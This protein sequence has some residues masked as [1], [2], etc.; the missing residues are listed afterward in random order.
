MLNDKGMHQSIG[1]YNPEFEHDACGVGFVANIKGEKSHEIVQNGIE[2]LENLKHRGAVGCDPKTG[3]GAGITTQIPHE[4]FVKECARLDYDLPDRGNYG[5]GLVFLPTIAEDRH[6]VE[7]VIEST[8]IDEDQV[9]LGLRDVPVN[10]DEIGSVAKSVMP[11]FK[12]I[13]VERGEDIDPED[14]ER[15]L[16]VI[17][18][19]IGL[20]IR[21]M[22]FGQKNYFYICNLSS[23]S[24]IYK[25]QLMAEQLR[26]FFPDLS[27]I[28]Y[29]SSIALVHSRYSTNT[30]PTWALAHPFRMIAHNGEINTLK[31][32]KNWFNAREGLFKGS[33]FE[34]DLIK[35]APIIAPSKSDSAAF[36]NVLEA[37]VHSGRSLPHALMMM[38]PE[39]FSAG[40]QMSEEKEAFYEY[41]SCLMEP[42]DGPSAI[43]FTDGRYIGSILDRNGLRPLRYWITDSDKIVM[44]SETGTLD[45]EEK[46][47]LK[48]GRIQPGKIFLV[49]TE[50]G[51]I[52]RDEEI[53]NEIVNKQDY[54]KWIDENL[55]ILKDQ[56]LEHTTP[57]D[58]P[59]D[60]LTKQKIFG[61]TLEDIKYIIKPMAQD[62]K[63]ATGSMGADTPLAI[64][65]KKPQLLFNYFKQQFAQVTNP[66][67]DPIREE[68]VMSQQVIL[69]PEQN[70]LSESPLHCKRLKLRRPV[71]TNQGL[72]RIRSLDNNNLISETISLVYPINKI[73]GLERALSEVF[74]R[75]DKLVEQGVSLIILSDKGVDKDNLPIPSLLACSGLHH[76]LVKKGTRTKVSIILETGEAREVHHF[77]T[78]IGFGANAINPYLAFEIIRDHWNKDEF[79]NISLDDAEENYLDA[80]SKGLF[81]VIS[82]MGISTIQS[83]CGAQIFEAVGLDLQVVQ[84]YFTGTVSRIGGIGIDL[85]EKEARLKHDFAFSTSFPGLESGGF[86]S[87]REEGEIHQWNPQTISILQQSVRSNDYK[88]YKKYASI[89]NDTTKN[90]GQLRSYLR[91]KERKSIPIEEVEPISEIVKRFATGAMSYGSISKEA[92]ETLA[93]AMNKLGGFSNTG[94][95]GEDPA[96]FLV[97][98]DGNLKRS[99][100]KQIAQGRF[101]V[102][103]EYLVNADQL[104]IKMAQGAKPGEGGQ[105]PGHKVS[106][107]IAKTRYTTEG[108]GLI[109]PPPHHDIYSIED[110][111]QLIY[112]LKKSNPTADV[113][114]KL[115]SEAGVGTIAAGVSK[116]K[117]DHILISGYE[118]GTGASPLT[119]IKHAGLPMELGIAETQQVLVMNDLRTRVRIQVDG[120]LKSGRDVVIAAML[121]A[122][123][124]GFATSALITMGCIMLRKC[125]LNTCSAG[126]ATQDKDLRKEFKGKPEDVI[127]YFNFIAE[128]VREIMAELG[129]RKFNDLIGKADFLRKAH[130]IDHWKAKYLD[131]T[132]ILH[133]MDVPVKKPIYHSEKQIH[134]LNKSFDNR[135]IESSKKAIQK[136][137]PVRFSAQVRNENRTIGTMLSSTI[138]KKY[139]LKG[140]K[141]DTITI[142]FEGSAGQSFGAFLSRG[143]TFNL[144]GDANDYVGKGLSGGKLVIKQHE[145]SKLDPGKNI[146]V[147]NV[148]LYG[149]ISGEAYI[150]GKAGERFAVRNSGANVVVEGIGDHGCEYMTGGRVVILGK[151]GRNFAA[152]MSGGIAYVWDQNN[153]FRDLCNMD[154][155]DLFPLKS[156]VDKNELRGFII[157]HFEKTNSKVAKKIL[158][159]WMEVESQFVKVFPKDYQRVLAKQSAENKDEELLSENIK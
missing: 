16:V 93:I 22:D 133:R 28:N 30:F 116:G 140:L 114:V 158:D 56:K 101:G 143:L 70:I 83:Y 13:I 12:H 95:G 153:N 100:I 77:T 106:K 154:M 130:K 53:K 110:L 33:E 121:G 120:Q 86:Y 41:H 115:V 88:I 150:S 11:V 46:S 42:W 141:D 51:R 97:D 81:K 117:A 76:H 84:K 103:I 135:L 67:I 48:K 3:D 122:D 1:M 61:Y 112:D 139:G 136:G 124:F 152:G 108:V 144:E 134:T 2:I 92:H 123:E 145:E 82:K 43:C 99:K 44:A 40:I 59:A 5:V 146:I 147:G 118:G 87:W 58:D 45:I 89:V 105:L 78:L 75:T 72:N 24:I 15:K 32:N 96:R 111:A 34:D 119:S 64:L 55:I 102:T 26:T 60:V 148:V 31:G 91:F 138:A 57:P 125:H 29:K 38:I 27:D 73:G 107:E 10:D 157:N 50:E 151:T 20:R 18:K 39:A 131:L 128:E 7:Q 63:E 142:D 80:I 71:I 6:I 35:I 109:S 4:F 47:V 132:N 69:G 21:A 36:D 25:G 129:I 156:Q 68:I 113:S 23:K 159:N 98:K 74:I 8:V 90:Y 54:K 126:I 65:S 49:D 19:R 9:F 85:V 17:R 14:F 127:N 137:I 79:E 155:I 104:Q 62:G 94:E 149:A 37:L 52:I 66:P